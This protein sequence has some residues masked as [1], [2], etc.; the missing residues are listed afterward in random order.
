MINEVIVI[1][2]SAKTQTAE[3]NHN[4]DTR[5]FHTSSSVDSLMKDSLYLK[6][7]LFQNDFFLFFSSFFF[8]LITL[9]QI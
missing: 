6:R 4:C 2:K 9:I 7:T 1:M 5:Q 3:K 8:L